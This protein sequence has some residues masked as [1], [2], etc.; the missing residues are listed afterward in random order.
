[1][2]KPFQQKGLFFRLAD[3]DKIMRLTTQNNDY[4]HNK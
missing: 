4:L 2:Q 3:T 1:M